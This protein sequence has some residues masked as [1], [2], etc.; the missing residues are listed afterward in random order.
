MKNK[1]KILGCVI[2]IAN[3]S[4]LLLA[5]TD[6]SSTPSKAREST[7]KIGNLIEFPDNKD[8]LRSVQRQY[9]QQILPNLKQYCGD[10]HWGDGAEADFNLEGY[11]TL[12][13]LLNGRKKW[14]KV[15]VRVAAKEMPP[16]DDPPLPDQEHRVLLDWIDN[17]L[18]SVDCTEINPG[19]VTIRRL[20]R[21]EYKNTIRDLMG[22]NY[23]PADQFPGDDVG[24]GFDNIAD[25]LSLPP[26]LME[27]YLQAAEEITNSA[28][29]DPSVPRFKETIPGSQFK[30]TTG[31]NPFQS[32]HALSTNGT[33]THPLEITEAGKY[34][35][36]IVA[37]GSQWGDDPVKMG[38]AVNGKNSSS[39]TVR[40][41]RNEPATFTLPVRLKEGENRL[42]VSFLNDFYERNK[43]DRNLYVVSATVS[44]P[45][46]ALPRNHLKL[47]PNAPQKAAAQRVEAEKVLNLFMSRAYRRRAT[48]GELDR[49]MKL[50]DQS[51]GEGQGFEVSLRFTF[52]AVLVSPYFLY[53]VEAPTA[54][55]ETRN[56]S[57]FEIA[58]SLS[59]F[60][61]S[62]MPDDELFRLA[63]RKQLSDPAEYRRQITR[64]LKDPKANALVENFIE[65]WLQLGHLEHFKPDPDLFPGVDSDMQRD[66]AI[67]TKLLFADL[68]KRNA[69]ILDALDSDS[70]FIN[71]RLA[72]HYGIPG[73]R[74]ENFR[75]V[76]MA[77]YGRR[78]LMTQASV[79]TLTS[80]PTR[81]S[82][83]KRGKWILENLLGEEPPPPDP[84][85]MQLEDQAELK[86]TL[87]Q[88]MEQHRADPACAVCHKVMDQL[89]FA[90]ENYDAVGKWRDMDETNTIDAT[91][92]LPDGT[93]FE[94]AIELQETV[95]TKMKDQF[96]RCM[97]EKMLI[98]AL[99]RGL[100]YFD[101]CSVD[102][103]LA[104]I[105]PGGYRFSDL[106]IAIAT[107]DPF[108]KR[109]GPP[110]IVTEE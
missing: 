17:L 91:G 93:L 21:T 104:E 12:D 35:L 109:T 101:E 2:L 19:R 99:G 64:M 86:G 9:T 25:V 103:I 68:I 89:G 38:V 107:S 8:D 16:K 18:T 67:E 62:S 95:K 73:I 42:E 72:E 81:T 11:V 57:D 92:E 78:G 37:Y 61:W 60:L 24:Y 28:I 47:I 3:S 66:M 90:L 51:R 82:P 49:L 20:N 23:E 5:N 87:R 44:G 110:A 75:K 55:G 80:N 34:E 85:A 1:L 106:V 50:Y 98:Y 65:Q 74:G 58:T 4:W 84:S 6:P 105:E 31:S 10:C 100:E 63:A 27:K 7:E 30:K 88:R 70:S 46:G 53:K 40:A 97:T 41:T 71:Q 29:V 39:K 45:I 94:G 48:Q 13:Q 26:I 102:K 22:V 69:S 54:L 32:E 77:K 52:Q 36:S 33:I 59:Y 15:L 76:S 108:V 83:V 43:G 56:L 96:V 14:K 79:L